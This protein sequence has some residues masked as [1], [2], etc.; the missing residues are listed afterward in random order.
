MGRDQRN[1]NG[2]EFWNKGWS[3]AERETKR[4]IG[5]DAAV[6]SNN[7]VTPEKPG[8]RLLELKK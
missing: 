7:N 1:A 8:T 5:V 4:R 6:K 3:S 2:T